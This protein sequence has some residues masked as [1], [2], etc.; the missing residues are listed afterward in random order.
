MKIEFL[1][2]T[3]NRT[4]FDFLYR[5]FQYYNLNEINA[6]IINQCFNV[7]L[8]DLKSN[9]DN[10][11]I[12]SINQV[13]LAKSRNLAIKFAN[14]DVCVIS[15]DDVI[16]LPD[17]LKNIKELHEKHL[18]IALFKTKIQL[19]DGGN[20]KKS[21]K[22]SRVKIQSRLDIISVSSIEISFKRDSIAK[23]N[24][25]FNEDLG[26]GTAMPGGEEAFFINDCIK[27]GLSIVYE[28]IFTV[29]HP[30]ESSGKLINFR[31][32]MVT[33]LIFGYFFP[34][35]CYVWFVYFSIRKFKLYKHLM[36]PI[37]YLKYLTKGKR[38]INELIVV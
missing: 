27:K 37:S 15:D 6:I 2:S 5:M 28:P 23:F 31:T 18:D 14:S 4:N 29:I 13:G 3:T 30:K 9:F 19:P 17:A 24:I 33:G 20:Y 21:Y 35:T 22:N 10:I 7:P 26:L 11:K 25:Q 8:P 32:I 16:Y 38:K 36:N 34:T 1:I 12:Y